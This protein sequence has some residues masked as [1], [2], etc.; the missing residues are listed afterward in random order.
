MLQ[1]DHCYNHNCRVRDTNNDAYDKKLAFKNNEPFISLQSLFVL[2][3]L[4]KKK[5][6]NKA[7]EEEDV[8]IVVQLKHLLS[9][10]N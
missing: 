3:Q 2:K 5:L 1:S 9:T 4:S 8:E 7:V 10:F 6:E